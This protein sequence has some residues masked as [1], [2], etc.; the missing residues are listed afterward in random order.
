MAPTR[1]IVVDDDVLLREGAAGLPERPR[2]RRGRARGGRPLPR[3]F[4]GDAVRD[5]HVGRGAGESGIGTMIDRGEAT[6]VGPR[7]AL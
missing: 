1:V 7:G 6:V 3:V 2:V 5:E 4:A